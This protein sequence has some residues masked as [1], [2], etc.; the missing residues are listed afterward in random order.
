MACLYKARDTNSMSSSGTV[1]SQ[2]GGLEAASLFSGPGE[3][4]NRDM[5][6]ELETTVDC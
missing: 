4:V 6:T 1:C 5:L 2:G 3:C